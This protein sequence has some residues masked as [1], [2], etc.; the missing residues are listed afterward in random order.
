MVCRDLFS[1]GNVCLAG[2][3]ALAAA[4]SQGCGR[5]D[6]TSDLRDDVEETD[7]VTAFQDLI[8]FENQ[9]TK[10]VKKYEAVLAVFGGWNT[11]GDGPLGTDI[12]RRA[13]QMLKRRAA[14]GR[15]FRIVAA[16]FGK[17]SRLHYYSSSVSETVAVGEAEDVRRVIEDQTRLVAGRSVRVVGHSYGGW[18]ALQTAS[19]LSLSV[20]VKAVATIDPISKIN[21]TP[22]VLAR[23]Y[24]R[25]QF[26]LRPHAGCTEAPSDMP[27]S[28]VN[29][30]ATRVSWWG[31]FFENDSAFLH[32]NKML[33]AENHLIDYHVGNLLEIFSPHNDIDSDDRVWN[34]VEQKFAG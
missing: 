19:R 21:C 5:E 1:K 22:L 15:H 18:L 25:S 7:Q 16:C 9:Q 14:E 30:V 8:D 33:G 3:L 6:S 23:S 10:G 24:L 31:N 17:T 4:V 12:F 29:S 34:V 32:S 11:C 20:N 13:A 26:S 28:V 2:I 27:S